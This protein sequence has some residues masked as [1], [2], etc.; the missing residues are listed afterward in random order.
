MT[1]RA[2][3]PFHPVNGGPTLEMRLNQEIHQQ[4]RE[5]RPAPESSNSKLKDPAPDAEAWLER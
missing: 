5:A 2:E 1:Q 3:S 4:N